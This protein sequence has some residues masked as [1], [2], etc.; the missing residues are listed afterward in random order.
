[1]S[2]VVRNPIFRETSGRNQREESQKKPIGIRHAPPPALPR[3]SA[4]RMEAADAAQCEADR[5]NRALRTRH[6]RIPFYAQ[7]RAQ[8]VEADRDWARWWLE[9]QATAPGADERA[10]RGAVSPGS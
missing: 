7:Y 9:F 1:M 3:H 6:G 4:R 8:D 5:R 10:R 2:P